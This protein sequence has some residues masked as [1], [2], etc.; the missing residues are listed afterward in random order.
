M[1]R[2]LKL[3]RNKKF[4]GFFQKMKSAL[5]DKGKKGLR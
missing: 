3:K 5:I 2:T 1:L 4:E